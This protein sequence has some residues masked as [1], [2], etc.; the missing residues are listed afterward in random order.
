[1]ITPHVSDAVG[2]IWRRQNIQYVDAAGNMYLR[3]PGLRIDVRG[4]KNPA[5]SQPTMRT[6]AMRAFKPSGL[7]V[8][9]TLLCEPTA[10]SAPFRQIAHRSN[11]SLGTVQRVITELEQA[12]FV[13]SVDRNRHLLRTRDL[14]TRWVEAYT[15]E[16]WPRLTLARFDVD[17]PTWWTRAENDLRAE[18][19]L[20]G[21]E[22]AA[23]ELLQYL[24]PSRAIIYAKTVPKRLAVQHRFRQAHGEGQAEIREQF[25]NRLPEQKRPIVPTPLI[26]A[27]LIASS[28]PRLIEAAQQL[29]DQDD[30]L[31]HLHSN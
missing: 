26:Y 30:L 23:H 27:D 16:L 18:H 7:K 15:L 1:V 20:W 6:T 22:T 14:F 13:A 11:A 10:I 25:W 29:K 3:W 2:E 19:A 8:L 24:R 21:G 28:D 12:G 4:R 9:F 31:R 5:Q 17:N